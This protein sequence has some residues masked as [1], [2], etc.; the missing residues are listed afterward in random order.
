MFRRLLDSEFAGQA[1]EIRGATLYDINDDEIGTIEDVIYDPDT[2]QARYAIVDSGGWLSS[3]RYLVPSDYIRSSAEDP[4]DFR[5]QLTRDQVQGLPEFKDEVL[6]S[7]ERFAEYENRFRPRWQSYGFT[8][9]ESRHPRITRFENRISGRDVRP[10]SSGVVSSATAANPISVYSVYSDRDKLES[11][12]QKLKDQGFNSSD[13]SV[14]F[15]DQGRTER[16]AME[17]NT[18][19]PEGAAVG[20][21]TGLAVGGVLGWLA[22]I[23]TLA[24]PGIGPLLAA[25]P[26]VAAL[27]GAG[28]VGAIGG[29]AGGLIGMGMPELEAKRYEK[30]I[31]EG[32]MLLSV[33]C[34]DPRFVASARSILESTGAKDVF[35]TGEKLAA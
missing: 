9:P 35:Q 15:P 6:T 34:S 18:K 30:E 3:R 20:G 25:G 28:A 27:A 21:G 2:K 19:A 12:V 31:R 29:L 32:R 7:D 4:D 17:H 23:G 8:L 5:V 13:I 1:D 33:R 16:F 14:V 22:G 11:A 24:I 26:I 10:I